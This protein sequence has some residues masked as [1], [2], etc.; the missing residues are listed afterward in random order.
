MMLIFVVLG[1]VALLLVGYGLFSGR[2][3][4]AAVQA[5][6]LRPLA[7]DDLRALADEINRLGQGPESASER[8]AAL[9]CESRA[10]RLLDEARRPSDMVAVSSAIAGGYH[11]VACGRARLDGQEWPQERALCFFDPAHGR[12]VRDVSWTPPG[13]GLRNVPACAACASAAEHGLEPAARTV[14]VDGHSMPYWDAPAWYG[15]WAAGYFSAS[16]VLYAGLPIGR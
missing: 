2:R 14:R 4:T 5:A 3:N 15:S 13:L 12:S 16:R 7:E 6:E 9:E 1:V 8:M 10:R 11:A